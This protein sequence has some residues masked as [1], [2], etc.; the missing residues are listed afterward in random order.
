MLRY[1][2]SLV[3]LVVAAALSTAGAQS[4][5]PF[6]FSV[7]ELNPGLGEPRMAMNRS[8]P[9]AALEAFYAAAA[10]E[11]WASAAHVLELSH[12]PLE[13]QA[14]KGADYA[15]KFA[16]VLE[17][18]LI[19][20]WA[21]LSDRPD[22]IDETAAADAPLA[23]QSRR[24]FGL[25][26]VNLPDRPVTLRIS[27]LKTENGEPVWMIP[28]QT[29]ENIP[30]LYHFYAPSAFERR[31]PPRLLEQAFWTLTWWEV[32]ALPLILVAA[33]GLASITWWIMG[34]LKSTVSGVTIAEPMVDAIRAPAALL[35]F[36][37]SFAFVRRTAFTLSGAVNAV[38]EPIVLGAVVIAAAALIVRVLDAIIERLTHSSGVDITQP[39][40]EADRDYYTT[41]SAVRRFVLV[42]LLIVGSAFVLIQSNLDRSLGFSLLASAGAIGI[43]LAFAAREALGNIMASLQ[44]GLAKSARIGDAVIFGGELA[45]VEHIGFT[46]VR[47]RTW[48]D[49]R[50]MTP[51]NQFVSETFENWTKTDPEMGKY[52]LLT[53]DHGADVEA[54]RTEFQRWVDAQDEDN[55]V[56]REDAK[57]QVTDQTRDGMEVR[58][59]FYAPDSSTAWDLH[60]DLRETMLAAAARLDQGIEQ[61]SAF[62]PREREEKADPKAA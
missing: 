47:L 43:V 8:T 29:V 53:L 17:R 56:R 26:L 2:L 49:R 3:L 30:A 19:V 41:L 31:L 27:R 42:L 58:F 50:L 38:I 10:D 14:A 36:A 40:A 39:D 32:I 6:V 21:G 1:A 55:L 11:D 7:E 34:R 33:F 51:V 25:S 60:C 48:D 13:E 24:S 28:R 5:E 9:Q 44:I 22:G 23:G 52:A 61:G 59:L 35:V 62:L 16:L 15:E 12:L 45:Y 37:A 54:L 20:D 18:G 57:V 46:H 4:S